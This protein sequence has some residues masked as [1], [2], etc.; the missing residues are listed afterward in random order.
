MLDPK[1]KHSPPQRHEAV[2][3]L[4]GIFY[5]KLRNAKFVEEVG[6]SLFVGELNSFK[7]KIVEEGV[8][9]MNV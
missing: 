2:P 9:V 8:L 7:E 3:L 6:S 5:E 1:F 4:S